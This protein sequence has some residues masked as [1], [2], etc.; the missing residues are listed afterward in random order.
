[1]HGGNNGQTE[2]KQHLVLSP[3]M[4]RRHYNMMRVTSNGSLVII[5]RQKMYNKYRRFA[6][7][8]CLQ[9]LVKIWHALIYIQS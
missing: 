3:Q 5:R 6:K 4:G 9:C 2:R 7:Y 8:R 1:M